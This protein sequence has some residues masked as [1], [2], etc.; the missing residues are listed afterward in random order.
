MLRNELENKMVEIHK[1]NQNMHLLG[2][3]EQA[4]TIQDVE[5]AIPVH[6]QVSSIPS[7][8]L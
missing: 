3:A 1:R 4:V 8:L 7:R 2:C 6:R 5:L